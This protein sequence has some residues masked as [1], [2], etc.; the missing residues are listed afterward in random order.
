LN[1]IISVEKYPKNR[2]IYGEN[3]RVLRNLLNDNNVAGKVKLVYI[4]PPYA[5][6]F[7]FES[8]K[9]NHAYHDLIDGADYLEFLRHR[10]V[11]LKE[12]LADDGSIYVHLDENMAF[13]IKILMDEIFGPKNFRNWITRKKCNPKNYTRKQYGNISD[14]ILFYMKSDAYVWN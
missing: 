6:G 1:C 10:L 3:L 9:Q 14:Y 11:L 2:L 8:R 12:L 7:G 4:D 5:T 13:P